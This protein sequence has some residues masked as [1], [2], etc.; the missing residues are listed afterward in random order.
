M[1]EA[2]EAL[3][4]SLEA[5]IPHMEPHEVSELTDALLVDVRR[6]EEH[7]KDALPGSINVPR[8]KIEAQIEEQ[9]ARPAQPVVVFCGSRGRSTLAGWT[10][11]EMGLDARVLRGGTAAWRG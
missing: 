3:L 7:E 4:A 9:M 5:R 1:A 10:L 2:Y 8:D 6:P 11:T